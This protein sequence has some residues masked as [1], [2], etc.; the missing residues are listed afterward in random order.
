M[1][2]YEQHRCGS[3]T[4]LKRAELKIEYKR[5]NC[6]TC[7]EHYLVPLIID[8]MNCLHCINCGTSYCQLCG[9]SIDASAT[10]N[11]QLD[12]FEVYDS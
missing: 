5:Q 1:N 9:K 8:E 11:H 4:S 10:Q 7:L 2:K 3:V 12:K 6:K